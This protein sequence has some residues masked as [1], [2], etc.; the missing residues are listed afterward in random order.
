MNDETYEKINS[1]LNQ[2]NGR[3]VMFRHI[4]EIKKAHDL[5]LELGEALDDFIN[6]QE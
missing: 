5:L 6:E 1:L 3:L 2:A 4:P